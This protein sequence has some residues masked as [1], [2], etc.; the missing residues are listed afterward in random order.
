VPDVTY[1]MS[2]R[3]DKDN[4]ANQIQIS[5]VT[6]SQSRAGYSSLVYDLTTTALSISTANLSSVGLAFLRNLSTS[7]A[8]TAQIGIEAG[9]SFIGFATLRGGE[10]ALVRLSAGTS[11]QAVGVAGTRLRVDIAEG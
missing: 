1:S 4:F 7:A 8:A 2:L 5:Q 9:G 11:Y 10:P 3:V 6:A